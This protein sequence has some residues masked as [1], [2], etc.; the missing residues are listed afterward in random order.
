MIK[1]K[2]TTITKKQTKKKQGQTNK[3]KTIEP[4]FLSELIM[5]TDLTTLTQ[6]VTKPPVNQ[7]NRK[8][9]GLGGKDSN[10]K[11]SKFY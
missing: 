2:T 7:R 8:F 6:T 11:V 10:F 5:I 1:R 9:L 4:I 3:Q